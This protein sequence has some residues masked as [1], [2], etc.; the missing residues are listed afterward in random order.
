MYIS[1]QI[2]KYRVTFYGWQSNKYWNVEI[3]LYD[4]NSKK[5]GEL[6]FVKEPN[7]PQADEYDSSLKRIYGYYPANRYSDII[8]ILRN[9]S[10]VSIA[11]DTGLNE[12][13]IKCGPE[14]AGE[15][16]T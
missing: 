6:K 3:D 15:G 7:V 8:D 9:E 16:E 1:Y 5:I 10:P 11:F 2:S 14:P 12:S 13:S 4:A